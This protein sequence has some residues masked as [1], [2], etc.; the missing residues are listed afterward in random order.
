[1]RHALVF[2]LCLLGSF[3]LLAQP[4]SVSQAEV[5]TNKAYIQAKQAALLGQWDDALNLFGQLLATD[6]EHDVLLYEV[7]RIHYARED[8]TAAL[9]NLEK[10]YAASP[11]VPYAMLLGELYQATGQNETGADLFE[12]LA[13][14]VV[15]DPLSFD[16]RSSKAAGEAE[17]GFRLQQ[18]LFLVRAQQ[19]DRAIKVYDQLED[20]QGVTPQLSRRKHAL[21]LGQGDFRNAEKELL[22]LIEAFPQ[23]L[24][25]RHLLAGFYG[26]RRQPE[27]AETVFREILEIEPADVKAQ[28]AL[29]GDLGNANAPTDPNDAD[30]SNRLLALMRRTDVELDL[31]IGRLLPIVQAVANTGE[32]A[33][34]DQGIELARELARVHPSEAKPLA[35]LGDLQFYGGQTAE[36]AETYRRTLE[37]DQS[38]Y[39]VWEQYLHA[40]YLDNQMRELRDAAEEAL[41]LF[42]N[43]PYVTFY[44]AL[45]EAGRADFDE[46]AS[47]LEQAVFIFSAASVERGRLAE[48][49]RNVVESLR[50]GELPAATDLP[51]GEGPLE[52]YLRARAA[53]DGDR[54]AEALRLLQAS[55]S[56]R[57]TNALHLELMG[58]LLQ[59]T[60]S[61]KTAAAAAY[62]RARAAGSVSDSLNRKILNSKS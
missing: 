47:L 58:D 48:N 1:M 56:E 16:Y 40:L 10:A 11:K 62:Q 34:A 46:A 9:D 27:K 23:D 22:R 6:P 54:P 32:A 60:E 37:L 8:N 4:G 29:A 25:Y 24:E 55:D 7:A 35:I 52:V 42:P 21:Y 14:R 36:A 31:K 61:D 39:V 20:S 13:D 59:S 57:N 38:V 41:D 3:V 43:R 50:G 17:R 26:L 30:E 51:P 44:Y 28:L 33:L 18:A 5:N 2:S 49:Y 12:E 45:G 19:I 15:R 53:A